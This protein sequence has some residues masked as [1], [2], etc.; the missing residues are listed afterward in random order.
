M[1][2]KNELELLCDTLK[3]CHVQFHIVN[4]NDELSRSVYKGIDIVFGK[5]LGNTGTVSG[6]LGEIEPRTAYMDLK[7]IFRHYCQLT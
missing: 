1:D 6:L 3:K 5:I 7:Q 2:Y 4:A